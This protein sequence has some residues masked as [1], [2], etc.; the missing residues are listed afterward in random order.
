MFDFREIEIDSAE[1]ASQVL[2]YTENCLR[3]NEEFI[4]MR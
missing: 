1:I 4:Y 3:N 2:S